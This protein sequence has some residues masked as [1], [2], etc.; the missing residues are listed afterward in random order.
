[1]SSDV[2]SDLGN[3]SFAKLLTL[4]EYVAIDGAVVNYPFSGLTDL[5]GKALRYNDGNSVRTFTHTEQTVPLCYDGDVPAGKSVAYCCSLHWTDDWQVVHT[6][7]YPISETEWNI[8][9]G[10]NRNLTND[11]GAYDAFTIDATLVSNTVTITA[12]PA[13]GGYWTTFYSSAG[14]IPSGGDHLQCH[15]HGHSSLCT[16]GCRW[17]R[18][19]R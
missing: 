17:W 7:T 13:L 4:G 16:A 19:W 12:K 15:R 11:I 6:L 9:K 10:N 3:A 8:K 5:G 1:M 14:Y 18:C 2:M